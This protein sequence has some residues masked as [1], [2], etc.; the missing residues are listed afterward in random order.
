MCSKH[1]FLDLERNFK[2]LQLWAL[3][4]RYSNRL[5]HRNWL[6][7]GRVLPVVVR[8]GVV[9][10]GAQDVVGVGLAGVA[11][12]DP[13][14]VRCRHPSPDCYSKKN[15]RKLTSFSQLSTTEKCSCMEQA[16]V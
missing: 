10:L 15:G 7:A 4:G 13:A 11:V 1:P 8:D 14:H 12:G 6:P 3:Y 9:A 16:R 2:S 5:W